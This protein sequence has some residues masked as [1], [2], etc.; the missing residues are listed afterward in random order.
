[1]EGTVQQSVNI[2]TLLTLET[3]QLKRVTPMHDVLHGILSEYPR[4]ET[5]CYP[6]AGRIQ[7]VPRD[8]SG[9]PGSAPL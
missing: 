7:K 8:G 3:I 4:L 1:M 5:N 9:I 6:R 2:C